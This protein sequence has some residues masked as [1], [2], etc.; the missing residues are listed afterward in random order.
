MN[1][2]AGWNS[3]GTRK[4]PANPRATTAATAADHITNLDF[5][6]TG[7]ARALPDLESV[8]RTVPEEDS[9]IRSFNST[10]RSRVSL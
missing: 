4:T 3:F 10:A 1:V 5:P 6:F 9:C 7:S 8:I 2:R